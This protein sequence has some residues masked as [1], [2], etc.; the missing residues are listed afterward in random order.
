[1]NSAVMMFE[2][3][4]KKWKDKIAVQDEKGE[5]TFASL[6]TQAQAIGTALAVNGAQP[7]LP[8]RPSCICRRA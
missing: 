6:R 4:A 2:K 7:A 5:V 3:T 1:M 8:A